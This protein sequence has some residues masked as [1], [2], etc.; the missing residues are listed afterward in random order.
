[1]LLLAKFVE[2]NAEEEEKQN[3]EEKEEEFKPVLL[4]KS[5]KVPVCLAKN[6]LLGQNA[7]QV[8]YV[9]EI[10]KLLVNMVRVNPENP[11][12]E[13]GDSVEENLVEENHVEENHADVENVA[14]VK[15]NVEKNVLVKDAVNV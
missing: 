1:M 6:H 10:Q 5:K 13:N 14:N 9:H 3:E 12:Q 4:E 7:R 2:H 15:E 8:I 11:L